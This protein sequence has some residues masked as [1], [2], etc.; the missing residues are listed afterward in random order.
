[1]QKGINTVNSLQSLK[2]LP[3]QKQDHIPVVIVV[4]LGN[5]GNIQ[6]DLSKLFWV[7]FGWLNT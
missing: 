4:L 1:M 7:L 6:V 2:L 3:L 5:H